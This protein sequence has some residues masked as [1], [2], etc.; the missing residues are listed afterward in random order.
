VLASFFGDSPDLGLRKPLFLSTTDSVLVRASVGLRHASVRKGVDPPDPQIRHEGRKGIPTPHGASRKRVCG[1]PGGSFLLCFG[2]NF[3][4]WRFPALP[5]VGYRRPV[6]KDIITYRSQEK[7][8]AFCVTLQS[9]RREL[10]A[11]FGVRSFGASPSTAHTVA[12]CRCRAIPDSGICVCRRKLPRL[13][14]RRGS[15]NLIHGA[16]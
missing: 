12:G 6:R 16:V 10:C 13:T 4:F 15:H 9:I 7:A 8:A 3:G 1:H 5:V 2:R 14:L 11:L